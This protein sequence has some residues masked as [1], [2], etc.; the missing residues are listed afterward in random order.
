MVKFAER[1]QRIEPSPTLAIS[2]RAKQMAAEGVDVVS[3][4]A[5]EPD[6]NTPEPIREAAKRA[7]DEGHTKY[8]PTAGIPQLREAIAEDY[9]R[10]DRSV[11]A[12]QVVVTVGGK[13]ALYNAHQVL[14]E[15][16]DKVLVPAP[17]WVS[18][19]AQANLAGAA[20]VEVQ[21]D[22]QTD[23]KLTAE[24]LEEELADPQVRGLIL[25]S[26]SN[27]TGACYTEDELEALGEVLLEH[28]RVVVLF[29]AIYDRL[30]YE[31][32]I[33]PDLVATVPA[34]ADR[35]VTFNGFSK[36]YAMTGW[37][38]GYA[39]GPRAIIDQM[40][41]LQSQSTSNATSFAQYGAL[42]ALRLDDEVIDEMRQTFRRRRDLIVERLDALENVTCPTPAG[43]F[44]VFADFSWYMPRH[45]ED[46]LELASH[47]LNEA[48]VATVPGSAFGSPESLRMSYATSDE[49]IEEGV[50][51]IE[52]ALGQL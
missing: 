24:K 38:L 26:P 25:C 2:A 34:L 7:L 36:A 47:L 27:P 45:F 12:D 48:H 29:D 4:S 42:E 8:E 43:A 46:D 44:Y 49:L 39:I 31:G 3:F 50:E 30:Y 17:Y 35:V 6:F 9:K 22:L 52:Q 23:F 51:R 15:E 33:A 28:E 37:R 10:R 19:P 32:S 16:G 14:F 5:G 21:T 13:Q 1:I 18:Y 20:P 40:A 11:D 41:K